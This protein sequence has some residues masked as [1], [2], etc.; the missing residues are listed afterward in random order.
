VGTPGRIKDHLN[1]GTLKLGKTSFLVLDETDRM[2]DMGFSEDIDEIISKTPK[3]RQTLLFS[4]T[5]PK[6]II[7]IS[8]KYLNDPV[9]IAIDE[10]KI[11]TGKIKQDVIYLSEREKYAGLT[12][13]L[14]EREG[15]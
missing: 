3:H 4:A 1:R 2:L 14:S 12:K 9:R 5:L 13:E 8:S 10:N 7:N 6:N 11:P 15:S